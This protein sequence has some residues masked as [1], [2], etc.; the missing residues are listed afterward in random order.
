MPR[1]YSHNAAERA[2]QDFTVKRAEKDQFI[3]W[4]AT[5]KAYRQPPTQTALAEALG[6]TSETLRL[7]KRDAAVQAEVR[8]RVHHHLQID[9]LSDIFNSLMVQATDPNNTRSVAA[10]RVLLER[11]DLATGDE[12]KIDLAEMSLDEI[13]QLA[14]DIY[15]LAAERQKQA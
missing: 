8:G 11:L 1:Y 12:A 7:W 14:A 15:D 10:A 9:S 4:L 5:P 2:T 3:E 6:V 13:Q